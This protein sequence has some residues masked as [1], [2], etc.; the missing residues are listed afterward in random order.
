MD[1]Y[2][3]EA[4]VVSCDEVNEL[5]TEVIPPGHRTICSARVNLEIK[6]KGQRTVKAK[7]DSCGSVSIAHENLMIEIKPAGKYKLPPIR[8]RGI[9]GKTNLLNKIGILRIK[10]PQDNHCD[11][12][13]YVF[14]EVIGQTEEMLLISMS[15]IIKAKINILHHMGK[16]NQEVC[17]DLQFWPNNKSFDEVC[18]DILVSDEVHKVLRHKGNIHPRD[19]YL[20]SDEFEEVDKPQLVNLLIGHIETGTTIIEEAY[21]TEIQLR[22]IVD[23]TSQE[24]SEQ[25]SDGDERMVK[26]GDN[27]SKFSKE[28]MTLGDDVYEANPSAP[29]ILR[30]VYLLYDKYV[31]ED[32]V[33]PTKNGAPRI[34]TKYKDVPYTYELQPEY[35]AGNKKYPCV[36]AMDWTGKKATA[37]VIRG[38]VKSTPVVEPCALP[39]CI[40]R[41]VIAPKY[42]PGQMKDDPDHGFRVCVNAL[43]NK[44]LKPY[45]STVP[46]ATDEIKRH[47]PSGQHHSYTHMPTGEPWSTGTLTAAMMAGAPDGITREMMAASLDYTN[48]QQGNTFPH[49]VATLLHDLDAK[50]SQAPLALIE[51]G[52]PNMGRSTIGRHGMSLRAVLQ[53]MKENIAL[54]SDTA[55]DLSFMSLD[56]AEVTA[57]LTATARMQLTHKDFALRTLIPLLSS[58]PADVTARLGC[59]NNLTLNKSS[60]V[61]LAL[62]ALASSATENHLLLESAITTLHVAMS[63]FP[64]TGLNVAFTYLRRKMVAWRK[65]R[66]PPEVSRRV[67]RAFLLDLRSSAEAFMTPPYHNLWSFPLHGTYSDT[68]QRHITAAD[69]HDNDAIELHRM[70]S[71]ACGFQLNAAPKPPG[72]SRRRDADPSSTDRTNPN[73]KKKPTAPLLSRDSWRKLFPNLCYW[74]THR[75]GGCTQATTG[76][77][78][79]E[80]TYPGKLYRGR[81][82]SQLDAATRSLIT[83]QVGPP[84][85][86]PAKQNAGIVN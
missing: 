52:G 15:A 12:L 41:L 55:N 61:T 14:N 44:C 10:Q 27:I 69:R 26:D 48:A 53:F 3:S 23:R 20:S 59:A 28:A 75:E 63:R 5:H 46:L 84:P 24:A 19:M 32:K 38:F 76:K 56:S 73:D 86:R 60:E 83:A 9:G 85:E 8:L 43:I 64:C 4:Q 45:A 29:I 42:A 74:H 2:I 68:L 67:I 78:H 51:F 62:D 1:A 6:D 54:A 57:T 17:D 33:F 18:M 81:H 40:S 13:C 7:L 25:Q 58:L 21:M 35:A 30:K 31:G 65:Q 34:M 80:H 70:L 11:L 50:T 77:C 71:H 39:R 72:S 79:D 22:R 37:Q 47:I 16:S 82:W 36:K 66:T 49:R